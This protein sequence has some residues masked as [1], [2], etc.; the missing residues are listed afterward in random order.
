MEQRPELS[1]D[2]I[3]IF[4]SDKFEQI[5][6]EPPDTTITYDQMTEN[7]SV[8]IQ[9]PIRCRFMEWYLFSDEGSLLVDLSKILTWIGDQDYDDELLEEIQQ[10][11]NQYF[12]P[13]KVLFEMMVYKDV[14]NLDHF[15]D[16]FENLFKMIHGFGYLPKP[17]QTKQINQIK[18]MM[19]WV[20]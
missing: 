12:D 15:P 7:G 8:T 18:E 11:I 1:L 20:D 3:Y 4:L 14:N 6:V 16:P 13:I 17:S 19:S 2:P 10:Q 5:G 9:T